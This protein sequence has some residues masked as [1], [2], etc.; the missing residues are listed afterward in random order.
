M[1]VKGFLVKLQY[2]VSAFFVIQSV[3]K[4]L[5]RTLV[6]NLIKTLRDKVFYTRNNQCSSFFY[7]LIWLFGTTVVILRNTH[8]FKCQW[9]SLN[10]TTFSYRLGGSVLFSIIANWINSSCLCHWESPVQSEERG[11]HYEHLHINAIRSVPFLHI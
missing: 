10:S 6:V 8:F 2:L 11:K 5:I 1:N 7:W 9:S 4:C 3:S